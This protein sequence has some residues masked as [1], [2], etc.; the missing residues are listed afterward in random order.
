MQD[1]PD[2]EPYLLGNLNLSEKGKW[3]T[4]RVREYTEDGKES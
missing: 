2:K 3:V 4:E 1:L